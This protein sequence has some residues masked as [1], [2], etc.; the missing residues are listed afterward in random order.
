M[1]VEELNAIKDLHDERLPSKNHQRIWENPQ[2][3]WNDS[4]EMFKTGI[5]AKNLQVELLKVL[6]QDFGKNIQYVTISKR[7]NSCRNKFHKECA[8]ILISESKMW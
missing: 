4:V 3:S 7:K 2:L 1:L 8:G 5:T 6:S